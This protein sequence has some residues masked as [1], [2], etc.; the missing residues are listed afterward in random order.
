MRRARRSRASVDASRRGDGVDSTAGEGSPRDT[1]R[2]N[3]KSESIGGSGERKHFEMRGGEGVRARARAERRRDNT[4]ASG[5]NPSSS[6]N[7]GSVDAGDVDGAGERR[8][9]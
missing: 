4:G 2:D 1:T 7:P 5:S 6:G 8:R 9:V 3:D